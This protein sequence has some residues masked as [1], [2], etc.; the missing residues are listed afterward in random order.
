MAKFGLLYLD[1]GR[2]KGKQIISPEWV[3]ASLSKHS[4]VN[5]TDY[6]YLWWRQWLNVNGTRVDGVTAKGNGGQRIYLWPSLEMVVVITGG[7]YNER[8]P[9]DELQ[10]KYILPAAMK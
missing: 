6:G 3:K 4:V 10:I 5:S 7:N 9:S 8:S 1:G 2:W